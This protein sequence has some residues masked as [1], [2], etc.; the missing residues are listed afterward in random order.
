VQRDDVICVGPASCRAVG[1]ALIFVARHDA[2][3]T[4]AATFLGDWSS[5]NGNGSIRY[6]HQLVQLGSVLSI[7]P[8]EVFIE[9]S[10][11]SATY[12]GDTAT[13]VTNW[14][15]QIVPIEESQWTL[16]SGGWNALLDDVTSLLIRIEL[17]SGTG[18][19]EAIDNVNLVPE[20]A[21]AVTLGLMG[22]GVLGMATR[23]RMA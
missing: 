12:L 10:G 1:A 3:P 7:V 22:L 13:T 15:T 11:G 14:T 16:N 5:L 17:V 9:G 4:V 8:Y 20:P 21:T 23:R 18:D 2:G 6:D 19:I